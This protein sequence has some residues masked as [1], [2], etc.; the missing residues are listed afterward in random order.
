MENVGAAVTINPRVLSERVQGEIV[1]VHLDT[2]EIYALNPTGARAWELLSA[3]HSQNDIARRI[4]DEFTVSVEEA[5]AEIARLL[6]ELV[7]LG[8]VQRA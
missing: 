1:L 4:S 8:L 3:G 5:A 2:N 6:H 7:D